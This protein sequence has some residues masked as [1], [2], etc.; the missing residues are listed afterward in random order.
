MKKIE[1]TIKSNAREQRIDQLNDNCYKVWVKNPATEGKANAEM[2]RL[3]AR[4][5]KVHL[6][7]INI[8]IGWKCRKKIVEIK[9]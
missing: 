1:V 8:I 2:I 3:L 9:G 6:N 7:Q 4:L 5:F